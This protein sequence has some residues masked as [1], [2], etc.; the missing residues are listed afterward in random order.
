MA[1]STSSGFSTP[2]ELEPVWNNVTHSF[3][4]SNSGRRVPL[5]DA[6][7]HA[8]EFIPISLSFPLD[9]FLFPSHRTHDRIWRRDIY[10]KKK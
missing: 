4:V 6:Q 5:V 8:A 7:G 2:L 10:K 1:A 3:L 9:L